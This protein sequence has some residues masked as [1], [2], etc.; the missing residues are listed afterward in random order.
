MND[1]ESQALSSEPILALRR[2]RIVVAVIGASAALLG[3]LPAPAPPAATASPASIPSIAAA[4][5][6]TPAE[7]IDAKGVPMRL[8]PAGE[9]TMGSDV[10]SA[11]EKPVHQVYLDAYYMDVYEVTNARYQACVSD[12]ACGAPRA[13]A[14][15]T[16]SPYYG[17]PRYDE[18][19]VVNVMWG[20]AR[21]YCRWRE[22]DLPTEAQWE[23]AARSTDARTYPWGEGIDKSM[24]NYDGSDTAAV[25]SYEKGKS[26]Y[27]LYDMAGNVW[28]WVSDRYAH[29]YY[30][31][32]PY[33][34]PSGS[35]SGLDHGLRGGSW[36][37][38]SNVA[39]ASFRNWDTTLTWYYSV[40][41]RCARNVAPSVLGVE[42]GAG[43]W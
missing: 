37:Y 9:F 42:L 10:G 29:I 8:V 38:G 24:A 19:P 12:G 33:K 16:R 36:N 41:F 6:D 4:P 23:K 39:R 28:E 40:G 25:G 32:S 21:S 22:A 27:G 13:A 43:E 1:L 11:D 3:C 7:I 34:N 15:S 18:Y 31:K 2:I 35:I 17:D 30:R 20:Q 5:S 26:P 14:S